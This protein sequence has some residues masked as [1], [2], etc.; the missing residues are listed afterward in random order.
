MWIN[1]EERQ[2]ERW[3]EYRVLRRGLGRR[4]AYEDRCKWSPPVNASPGYWINSKSTII[5]TVIA[6]WEEVPGDD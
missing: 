1:C 3:G 2:P 5:T 6:W 4:P